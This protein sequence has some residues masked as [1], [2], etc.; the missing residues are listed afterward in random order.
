M[1]NPGIFPDWIHQ[2]GD[3]RG[4]RSVTV[5]GVEIDE[6][7]YANTRAGVV[8]AWVTP[9]VV[10]RD[11]AG[12]RSI[13]KRRLFGRVVVEVIETG[14]RFES[15]PGDRLRR[16]IQLFLYSLGLTRTAT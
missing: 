5:D 4:E 15:K 6:V 3:G 7:F 13:V 2:V 11:E 10:T 1:N 12:D 14:E 9:H 8:D 16:F